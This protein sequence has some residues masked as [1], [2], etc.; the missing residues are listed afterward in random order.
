MPYCPVSVNTNDV[1]PLPHCMRLALG[2]R[3]TRKT[4]ELTR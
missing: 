2:N 1:V 3:L 4:K